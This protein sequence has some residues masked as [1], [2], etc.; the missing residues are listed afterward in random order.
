MPWRR[1][2]AP[3]HDP[4]P[5]YAP[6]SVAPGLATWADYVDATRLN[7]KT[8]RNAERFVADNRH[9]G[10]LGARR[11]TAL[12]LRAAIEAQV[13]VPAPA[14][15]ASVDVIAAALAARRRNLG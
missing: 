7:D 4:A 13:G 5:A 6:T 15:A 9:L 14:T 11:E 8:V 12:R 2:T 1:E 10:S 3:S